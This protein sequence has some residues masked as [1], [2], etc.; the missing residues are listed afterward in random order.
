MRSRAKRSA[1]WVAIV[2]LAVVLAACAAPAP[3][4]ESEQQPA[5]VPVIDRD[6]PDPD[7]LLVDGV[8]FAY[9][10]NDAQSNVQ[11]ATSTDLM[12]WTTLPDAMPVLPD[13]VLPGDTWAPEVTRIGESFVLY[14]TAHSKTA[15]RQC[16]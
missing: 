15:F 11:V 13:W 10:T 8:W 2:T 1:A 6:F 7:V 5:F 9:A 12:E 4:P 14:F 16:I 3:E